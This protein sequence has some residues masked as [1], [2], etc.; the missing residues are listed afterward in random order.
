MSIDQK[1]ETILEEAEP[2]I[3]LQLPPRIPTTSCQLCITTTK[4][5][6][7]LATFKCHFISKN[8]GSAGT[9]SP[10][11]AN[12]LQFLEIKIRDSGETILSLRLGA[13]RID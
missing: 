4:V 5:I 6:T 7:T 8:T 3:A 10:R 13:V 12:N 9:T 1:G 2:H 11:A